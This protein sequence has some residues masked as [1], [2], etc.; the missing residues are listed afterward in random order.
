MSLGS[1]RWRG[2]FESVTDTFVQT[3]QSIAPG[4]FDGPGLGEWTLR[5]LVGHTSRALLTVEMYLARAPE[6]I[7]LDGPVAYLAAAGATSVSEAGRRAIAERG[8]D[9]GAAL[10]P[11]PAASVLL[12]AERVTALVDRTADDALCAT[13]VGGITLAAYLPTRALEL[14]VHTLDIGAA[15]GTALPEQLAEPIAACLHLVAAA[16]GETPIAADV[17][18][19]L[20]GRRELPPELHVI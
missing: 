18:L 16:I 9:A 4:R 14:T 19:A 10:G 2:I 20:L 3:V 11:D 12:I 5:D 8:R 1:D 7:T 15:L 13:P 6:T 17:L